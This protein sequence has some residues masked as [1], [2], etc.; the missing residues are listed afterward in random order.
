M[1]NAKLFYYS[2]FK[3][4]SMSSYRIQQNVNT[5]KLRFKAILY[6]K[7]EDNYLLYNMNVYSLNTTWGF[8]DKDLDMLVPFKSVNLR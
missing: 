1:C 3:I 8:K 6:V 2:N 5:A 7:G 4:I